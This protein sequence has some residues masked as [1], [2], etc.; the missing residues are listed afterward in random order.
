M[1]AGIV[2][3]AGLSRRFGGAN[4][5]LAAVDSVP[6]I[7]RVV[8]T[9]LASK[10]DRVVV[11]L[12][13]QAEAVRAVLADLAADERLSFIEN[14]RPELGQSGSVRVGLGVVAAQ[15]EGALFLMGDQ[16]YLEP[17]IIDA[18]IGVHRGGITLPAVGGK[19]RNPVIFDRRFYPDILALSGDTGARA[20]IEANAAQVTA[21]TFENERPFADIDERSDMI[22]LARGRP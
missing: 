3:A 7:R 18:L 14:A 16:P 1:I 5:L 9:A 2:L 12:G 15:C 19:R 20:I 4:K 10:L 17:G 22:Q 13:H 11:V 6:L 8:R 21:L